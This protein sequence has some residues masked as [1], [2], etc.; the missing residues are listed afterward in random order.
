[1]VKN[2]VFEIKETSTLIYRVEAYNEKEARKT[3]EKELSTGDIMMDEGFFEWSI[4]PIY[5]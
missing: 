5:E 3:V 1:M 4:T 2:Y